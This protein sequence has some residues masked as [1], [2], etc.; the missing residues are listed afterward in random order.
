MA[1]PECEDYELRRRSLLW[2]GLNRLAKAVLPEPR[3]SVSS[4]VTGVMRAALGAPAEPS[5]Y[6]RRG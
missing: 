4:L 3:S 1:C 2:W 5:W 6:E